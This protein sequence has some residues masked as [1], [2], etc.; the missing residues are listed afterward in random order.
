MWRDLTDPRLV[1]DGIDLEEGRREPVF[2]NLT[3][4][5]KFGPVELVVDEHKV[6]RFAFTQDDYHPWHL[7][8]SPF[9]GPIA[10][11][12]LLTNDLVQ[13]FTTQFAASRTVGLHTE[14]QLWFDDAIRLG[15]RV[16]LQGEYVQAYEHRGHGY[17]VMEA[18]AL[19]EDGRSVLRHRGVEILRT[20]PGAVVGRGAAGNSSGREG[21]VSG[22]V[23]A[24]APVAGTADDVGAGT[25]IR[26]IHK[27]ITQEQA[28]VFSRCGEY[29]RN[30]HNDLDLARR[31]QLRIPIVQGQQQ[32][33]LITE[34]LTT[35]FG[36]AWL[37]SGW[38]RVKFVQPVEVFD[39]L[40]VGGLVTE[41]TKQP[42]GT[43]KVAAE[44]WVRR[45]DGK[46]STVGWASAMVGG[47]R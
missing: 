29:V 14:E 6:K 25:A 30:I 36:T 32:C 46:L 18:Q 40:E 28:S 39:E 17:V 42:D 10:H 43:S 31:A 2:E 41:V 38:L 37:T 15:E 27:T 16:S 24:G 47:A 20:V 45:G 34:R 11:A 19:G 5:E 33:C 44:V 13:L 3:I 8:S 26:P 23:P 35:F 1:A 21:Q 7:Q 4:P 12:G 22:E 9:G